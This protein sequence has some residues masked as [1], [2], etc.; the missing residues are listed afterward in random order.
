MLLIFE[1]NRHLL[2]DFDYRENTLYF[3]LKSYSERG[4]PMN[5]ETEKINSKKYIQRYEYFANIEKIQTEQITKK[6]QEEK[7]T[8]KNNKERNKITNNIF[9]IYIKKNKR[10]KK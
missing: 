5:V 2:N 8:K 10:K 3:K 7:K 4:L 6:V 9:D 1:N